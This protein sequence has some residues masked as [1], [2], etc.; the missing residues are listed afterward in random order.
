MYSTRYSNFNQKNF[1]TGEN[2][3]THCDKTDCVL[4]SPDT[5]S[6]TNQL[7]QTFLSRSL[8]IRSFISGGVGVI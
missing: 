5:L 6:N 8:G 4:L 1:K 3:K 7:S 2:S